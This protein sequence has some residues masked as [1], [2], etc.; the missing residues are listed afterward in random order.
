MPKMNKKLINKDLTIRIL[1]VMLALLMWFYVITEKNPEITKDITIPVRLINTVFLEKSNMVLANDSNSF[2][3][4]LRIKGNK[5]VLDKLNENTINAYVDFQGHNLKGEN[6]L[7]I[8]IGG[9]PE[10]VDIIAKSTENLKVLLESKVSVQKSVQLNIMGNPSHGLAAMTPTIAPNDVVITGAESQVNKIK[11]VR[12]DVDIASVNAEVKKILPVRV[13]DENGK[14]IKN[15]T[16]EPG[17][18][19]VS[20]PIENTKRVSLGIDISGKPADGYIISSIS[21]Q[22]EEILITGKQQAIEGINSLK[23]EKID[24]N[25]GT[26]N[27][28]KEVKLLIPEGIEIVNPN[29]K[30]NISIKI[31]K[32]KTSE[33]T[34]ENLEYMNLPESLELD[35]IQSNVKVTLRGAE[36]Q[37][38]DAQR[39]VKFYVDLTNA[40]EGTNSLNVLWEAPKGIQVL[41][42]AP[43]HAVVVLKKNGEHVGDD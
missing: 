17:N 25:E 39:T 2:T 35:S 10:G 1:S 18:V 19:E 23:T 28:S 30:V 22:P 42:V 13:L 14:N 24:I 26:E 36:S 40:T 29:E 37:L 21:V 16:I 4:T 15:I 38:A 12:V 9:I 34:V 41:D 7:K 20:I 6:Y 33:I 43:K 31:E 27:I 8:N 11:S 32:I 5:N 3:L